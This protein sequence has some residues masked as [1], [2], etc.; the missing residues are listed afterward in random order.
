VNF[1]VTGTDTD[2]GKTFFAVLLIRALRDAGID[3]VG[4]KPVACGGW[5][6]VDALVEAS[7]G[8]ETR[9][10][11]CPFHFS[12]PASP[13]TA[14]W[15]EEKIVDPAKIMRAYEEL[16]ARHAVVVV[17]GVGGW[18]VPITADW[19]VADF[20]A[21][22]GLLV[23]LVVRNRLGAINH[24]LLTLESIAVRGLE[25]AGLVL[26]HIEAPE[27]PIARTNRAV[28]EL[29]PAPRVLCEIVPGQAALHLPS[30]ALPGVHPPVAPESGECA[31][32]PAP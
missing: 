23:I 31:M 24:T 15:A 3:A 25:C 5:E 16:S 6:D 4:F 12:T 10:A 13:L 19:S 27:D 17:E 2:V 14:S 7:G 9:E 8:V 26:N 30:L 28:F 1:F 11:T 20:A 29:R 21:Q 18:L 32:L 22:L